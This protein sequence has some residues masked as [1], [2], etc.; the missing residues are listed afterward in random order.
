MGLIE[1][2]INAYTVFIG[3]SEGNLP[4]GKTSSKYDDDNN[5][6]DHKEKNR[7]LWPK[8]MTQIHLFLDMDQ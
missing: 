7:I 6:K 3:K 4:L 1:E 2:R 5:K 8:F